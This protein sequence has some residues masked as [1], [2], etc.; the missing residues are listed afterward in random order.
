MAI[1][2]TTGGTINNATV[3]TSLVFGAFSATA[4]QAVV[5]G[6]SILSTGVSVSGITDT[7]G[8]TYTLQAAGNNGSNVRVELWAAHGI[9]GN[10]SSVITVA[11][12]GSSLASAAFEEYAGVTAIGNVSPVS[13][14]NNTTPNAPIATQ[15]SNN[16]G[17]A[18]YGV[19]S[20]SGDTIATWSVTIRSE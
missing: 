8:N 20:S 13:T 16:W 15:D 9:T 18:A 11:L 17:V 7:A 1:S 4:T 19:A 6:V 2:F 10:G 3:G 12:S 14:G 5:V